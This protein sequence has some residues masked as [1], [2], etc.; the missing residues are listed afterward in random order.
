MSEIEKREIQVDP[1]LPPVIEH[2]RSKDANGPIVFFGT[3]AYDGWKG[4]YVPSLIEA[5]RE[6]CGRGFRVQHYFAR[7]CSLT[8]NARE[9]LLG[10]YLATKAEW[11][12]GIDND[13]GWPA[14][15]VP[16]MIALGEPMTCAAVPYR[17][18]DVDVLMAGGDYS[19]AIQFNIEPTAL[20]DLRGCPR[21]GGFVRV[22][23]VGTAFYL[24]RRDAFLAMAR[25]HYQLEIEVT[26]FVSFAVF[27]QVIENRRHK[28]EDRSFFQRWRE[29]GGQIWCIEDADITHTGP[30]TVGGNL[31]HLLAG[32]ADP[33]R[34]LLKGEAHR[35]VDVKAP[36]KT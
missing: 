26:G 19:Q 29:M 9:E 8:T 11:F 2:L 15:L 23:D 33:L 14:D 36:A 7:G 34:R 28:G 30:M 1:R 5:T 35:L 10:V 24:A 13:I 17:K 20:E 31:K 4:D 25:R 6:L 27:A 32:T 12:C 18:V 16:R 3:P 22:P 21:N